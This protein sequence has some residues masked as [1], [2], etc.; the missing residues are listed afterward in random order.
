MFFSLCSFSKSVQIYALF[1]HYYQCKSYFISSFCVRFSLILRAI[2]FIYKIR[3]YQFYPCESV[4]YCFSPG[5][6]TPELFLVLFASFVLRVADP[7]S[8][9]ADEPCGKSLY[10]FFFF[11]LY[12][13]SVFICLIREIC[14]LLFFYLKFKLC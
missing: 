14:V 5:Y 8:C 13:L 7:P 4:F 11:L 3:V 12:A 10:Y 6:Y 1:S 2:E 9:W